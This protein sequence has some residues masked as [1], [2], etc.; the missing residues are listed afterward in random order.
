MFDGSS[1]SLIV[2]ILKFRTVRNP[3]ETKYWPVWTWALHVRKDLPNFIALLI[4]DG[5]ENVSMAFSTLMGWI[6][7][8]SNTLAFYSIFFIGLNFKN[9]SY[10]IKMI[11]LIKAAI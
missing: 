8:G 10:G 9:F 2:G 5:T 4:Q 3:A 1:C 11:I 6:L 7:Q